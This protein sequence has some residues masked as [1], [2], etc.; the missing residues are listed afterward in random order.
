M[1]EKNIDN[2]VNSHFTA[3]SEPYIR[4]RD[5]YESPALQF[6]IKDS[7]HKNKDDLTVC[8]MGGGNGNLLSNVE[9]YTQITD[10][11]NIELTRN[12]FSNLASENIKSIHGSIINLPIRDN[13]FDYVIVEDVLHHLIGSTRAHS[14][15][16]VINAL[17]EM[18]RVVK[19]SGYIIIDEEYNYHKQFSTILFHITK[20]FSKWNIQCKYFYIHKDIIV[21]FLTPTEL[22]KMLTNI[23]N[24]KVVNKDKRRF[25]VG[26]RFRLTLL[27]SNIGRMIFVCKKT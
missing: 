4:I 27:M 26:L 9:K 10:L 22:T 8:D 14:K 6:I 18:Q 2:K 12:Y 19:N 1:S 16:N 20:Q 25:N 24:I 21:S 3:F 17:N 23:N 11:C 7:M 15:Q 13:S 5:R